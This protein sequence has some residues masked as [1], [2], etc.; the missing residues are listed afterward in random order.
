MRLML[1]AFMAK[2]A[3]YTLQEVYY[4]PQKNF[5]A[6]RKVAMDFDI[7]VIGAYTS[8]WWAGLHDAVGMEYY[9]F[10]GYKL[11][12][13]RQFQYIEDEYMKEDE[14]DH[15]LDDPS[16]FLLRVYTPRVFSNLKGLSLLPPLKSLA[17]G[18]Y[19]TFIYGF[20]LSVP[21]TRT[22]IQNFLDMAKPA[23]DYAIKTGEFHAKMH[24]EGQ[25]CSH[26]APTLHPFDI[27][28]DLLRGMRGTMLDMFQVPDKLH[29][30]MEKL[31]P[32]SLGNA[33]NIAEATGNR[34]MFI[35]LH[36]GADGFMSP[37]Q[38]EEYY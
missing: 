4:D 17:F 29:S 38:F 21:E 12:E 24:D 30:A 2:Y 19:G 37:K 22:A 31:Y 27:I 1:D 18:C 23:A 7:D 8:I 3:G 5:D 25:L 34:Q 14:Y 11:E 33:L 10:A 13:S 16:D 6:L 9:E 15:L 20:A 32:L 35:P 26:G 28:S 36:R